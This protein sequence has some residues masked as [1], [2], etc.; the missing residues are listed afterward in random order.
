MRLFLVCIH[1]PTPAYMRETGETLATL[2]DHPELEEPV[3]KRAIERAVIALAEFHHR[4]FTHG[5]ATAENVRADLEAGVAHWFDFETLHDPRCPLA[6][7][8]AD[9]VRALSQFKR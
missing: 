2:L 7:R 6:W 5:H 9:D 8:R 3:W 1:D 4:G